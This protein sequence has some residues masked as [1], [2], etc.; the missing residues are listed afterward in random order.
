MRDF[1]KHL[2][3]VLAGTWILML[4]GQSLAET[5]QQGWS[6][7][8]SAEYDSNPNMTPY[9]PESISRYLLEPS[10]RL[11]TTKGREELDLGFALQVARSSNTALSQNREDPSLFFGWRHPRETGEFGVTA[12]YDEASTRT[13]EIDNLGLFLI[14]NTRV[15]RAVSGNWSE[16]LTERTTFAGDVGY[17]EVTYKKGTNNAGNFVDFSSRSSGLMLSYAWSERHTTFFKLA[18]ADYEPKYSNS[19]SHLT[20]ASAGWV[21]KVS[22]TLQGTLV[23]GKSKRSNAEMST[24][25]G[26][27]LRYTGQQSGVEFRVDRQISPS[28]LGGF[29]T[30]D[31]A[32][33][34][35][36]YTLSER[37]KAG[38]DLGWHKNKSYFNS[39]TRTSGVWVNYDFNSGWGAQTYY[40]YRVSDGGQGVAASSNIVGASLVYNYSDF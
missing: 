33:A 7:K 22:D 3:G 9:N 23:A 35:W 29:V 15:N 2:I 4:P 1:Y 14:E 34:S 27:T 39:V 31:Q 30:V 26:L 17:Q 24:Q 11:R 36:S 8:T 16:A 5:W 6:V 19:T 28:G 25:G 32:S 12:R 38:V 10:Y 37:S 20:T 21:W 13:I 40:R 18:Y